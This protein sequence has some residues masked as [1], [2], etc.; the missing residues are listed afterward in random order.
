VAGP[1]VARR[2]LPRAGGLRHVRDQLR[3]PSRHDPDPHARRL[4]GPPPPQGLRRRVR[5][6]PVQELTEGRLMSDTRTVDFWV[7]GTEE[8]QFTPTDEGSQEI[9]AEETGRRLD[10]QLGRVVEDDYIFNDEAPEEERM[11]LNMG[12]Q[13]PSTHGVL[14]LQLEL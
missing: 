7:A 3:W 10:E 6:R 8:P 12:P 11:I 1:A 2:Q 13:H 14:R 4:G 9:L 5:A